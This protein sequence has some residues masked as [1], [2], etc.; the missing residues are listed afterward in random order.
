MVLGATNYRLLRLEQPERSTDSTQE[1]QQEAQE[2]DGTA[3]FSASGAP[4]LARSHEA[5][6]QL[7]ASRSTR[8][9]QYSDRVLRGLRPWTKTLTAKGLFSIY[10]LGAQLNSGSTVSCSI[11]LD[12]KVISTHT[13]TGQYANVEC[14]GSN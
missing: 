9:K 11:T 2:R 7:C 12:G 8:C 3:G 10:S 5:L 6:L 4:S 14:S 13:S 1:E